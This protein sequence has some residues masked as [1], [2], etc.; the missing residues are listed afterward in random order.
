MKSRIALSCVLVIASVAA[1]ADVLLD[2]GAGPDTP[3]GYGVYGLNSPY[4]QGRFFAS[5]AGEFT[6]SQA[7]TVNSVAGWLAAAGPAFHFPPG[8]VDLTA[9]IY[10]NAPANPAVYGGSGQ[11][12]TALFSASFALTLCANAAQSSCPV[13]WQGPAGLSWSLNPGTYWVVFEGVGD[14]TGWAGMPGGVPAPL[15]N[16]LFLSSGQDWSEL[17]PGGFGVQISGTQQ[18]VGVP[19]PGT[20]NLLL[21]G[22]ALLAAARA[23]PLVRRKKSSDSTS[24]ARCT[25]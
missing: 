10:S 24:I 3:V 13:G 7:W 2:T 15:A 5:L 21:T 1:H 4:G 12:G 25:R 18:A 11:P 14:N 9:S 16:S 23:W 8:P 20:P 6:N 22:I 17:Y 19:T